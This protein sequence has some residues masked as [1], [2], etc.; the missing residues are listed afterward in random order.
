[1]IYYI[2]SMHFINSIFIRSEFCYVILIFIIIIDFIKSTFIIS[3]Y[4][5][6]FA[7]T[8]IHVYTNTVIRKYSTSTYKP[9]R[10]RRGHGRRLSRCACRL[11]SGRT[12]LKWTEIVVHGRISKV[13]LPTFR[14]VAWNFI[15]CAGKKFVI[16][17]F[18]VFTCFSIWINGACRFV[19]QVLCTYTH[20]Y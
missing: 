2:T 20:T 17:N 9:R 14:F 8:C 12:E 11:T 3:K 1:M 7:Q 4:A 6:I 15:S 10:S 19:L 5:S 18:F 16:V 13:L